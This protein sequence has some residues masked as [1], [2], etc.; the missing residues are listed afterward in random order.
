MYEFSV[1][2]AEVG[3]EIVEVQGSLIKGRVRFE[4]H[5]FFRFLR[6]LLIKLE[7]LDSVSPIVAFVMC[8]FSEGR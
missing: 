6:G 2:N 7:S 1:P 4:V 5:L 8:E 3:E